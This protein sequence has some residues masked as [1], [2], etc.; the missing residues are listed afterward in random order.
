MVPLHLSVPAQ[1]KLKNSSDNPEKDQIRRRSSRLSSGISQEILNTDHVTT[2]TE[3][4][5]WKDAV[6]DQK[7]PEKGKQLLGT[8]WWQSSSCKHDSF[9]CVS[10]RLFSCNWNLVTS[11]VQRK[12]KFVSFCAALVAFCFWFSLPS[13]TLVFPLHGGSSS[14]REITPCKRGELHRL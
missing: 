11:A 1:D 9:T 6:S 10:C 8:L 3:I 13:V 5:P 4:Q 12:L 14:S 2:S 7:E